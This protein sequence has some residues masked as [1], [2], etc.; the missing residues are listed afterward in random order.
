MTESVCRLF[1][2]VADPLEHP[3]DSTVAQWFARIVATDEHVV[4]VAGYTPE[5][6][7]HINGL[8]RQRRQMRPLILPPDGASHLDA[9][10]LALT[11]H[12]ADRLEGDGHLDGPAALEAARA[13]R[14]HRIPVGVRVPLVGLGQV[15][16][17]A[18]RVR[19]EDV[20]VPAVEEGVEEE[21]HVIAAEHG[22]VALPAA[23]TDAR[24]IAIAADDSDEQCLAVMNDA[25][26]RF[27]GHRFPGKGFHLDQAAGDRGLLPLR[28]VEDAVDGG[29]GLHHGCCQRRLTG[30]AGNLTGCQQGNSASEI[31]HGRSITEG[32][33]AAPSK[34]AGSKNGPTR[35]RTGTVRISCLRRRRSA[36]PMP[37]P[38]S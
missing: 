3:G 16:A 33:G 29:R 11:G 2:V 1:P 18:D 26:L 22:T 7:Q 38:A 36:R 28:L 37:C 31:V 32:I 15:D 13:H 34:A 14:P 21:R 6:T 30:T 25:D 9:P 35:R 19:V 12:V 20:A 27:L 10:G 23:G 5:V 8:R 17:A 4:E 24:R